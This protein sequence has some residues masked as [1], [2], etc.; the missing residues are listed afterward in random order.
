[1]FGVGPG[2][3]PNISYFGDLDQGFGA[4]DQVVVLVVVVVVMVVVVVV[5]V[6]VTWSSKH[7]MANS[8]T[9]AVH[10]LRLASIGASIRC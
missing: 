3:T 1:M 2:P 6:V 4:L 8:I 7:A 10:E 5:V 9:T